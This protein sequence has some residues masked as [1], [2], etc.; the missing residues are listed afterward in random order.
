MDDLGV[1]PLMD[2]VLTF[3]HENLV[4]FVSQMW[5]RL[6][7]YD[8]LQKAWRPDSLKKGQLEIGKLMTNQEHT[9]LGYAPISI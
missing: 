5:N 7:F 8:S 1:T 3:F 6:R 4:Y 2:H 9:I